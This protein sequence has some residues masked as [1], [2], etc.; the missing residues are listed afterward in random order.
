MMKP[1]SSLCC[2]IC[3]GLLCIITH[4]KHS[5][6]SIVA[7][8]NICWKIIHVIYRRKAFG[9]WKPKII[10]Y[11]WHVIRR[12]AM[13][14]NEIDTVLLVWAAT[15]V[16][17]EIKTKVISSGYLSLI[18]VIWDT[19]LSKAR[20][21]QFCNANNFCNLFKNWLSSCNGD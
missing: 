18:D 8:E 7:P 15:S 1:V 19:Q 21:Y 17:N 4:K 20:F 14:H 12:G 9:T 16:Y 13:E 6:K 2:F 5:L 11:L 10:T 3:L